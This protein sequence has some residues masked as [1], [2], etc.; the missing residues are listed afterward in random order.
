M[1][2][3]ER[4][5]SFGKVMFLL[6]SVS[7]SV[8]GVH[9]SMHLGRG[10]YPSMHLDRGGDGVIPDALAY[11]VWSGGVWTGV[12]GQGRD[13]YG[14]G[15][16]HRCGWTEGCGQGYVHTHTHTHTHTYT[17]THTHTNTHIHTHIQTHTEAGGTHPTGMHTCFRQG[18]AQQSIL[19]WS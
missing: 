2:I 11:G 6:L 5:R 18:P 12:C 1:L 4:K 3:T 13:V 16:G 19:A 9:P 10:V 14:Q 17:H 8:R 7:Q 15:C